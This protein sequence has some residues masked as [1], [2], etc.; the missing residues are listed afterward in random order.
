M[1][2]RWSNQ[3][4]GDSHSNSGIRKI[5]GMNFAK[6]GDPNFKGSPN[7][8]KYSGANGFQVMHLSGG[9]IHASPDATRSRY[10]FLDSHTLNPALP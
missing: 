4:L 10:E 2:W 6:V 7:W 3:E 9:E 5:L 8:P 1:G